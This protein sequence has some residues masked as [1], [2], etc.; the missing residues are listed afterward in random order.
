LSVQA[1]RERQVK[2]QGAPNSPGEFVGIDGRIGGVIGDQ[3]F[4]QQCGIGGWPFESKPGQHLFI[5][6][7]GGRG[8]DNFERS[9]AR[10]LGLAEEARR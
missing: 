4:S 7:P 8:V 9:G 10:F 6:S 2:A 5:R 3:V 1:G